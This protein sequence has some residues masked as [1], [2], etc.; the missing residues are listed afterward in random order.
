MPS[1]I[2]TR[3]GQTFLLKG[4]IWILFFTGASIFELT[5]IIHDIS[6][7]KFFLTNFSLFC[8]F[9]KIIDRKIGHFKILL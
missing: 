2:Y 7:E 8:L 6:A 3:G 4:Q 1:L 9:L 5:D